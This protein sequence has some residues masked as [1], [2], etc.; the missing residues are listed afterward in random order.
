MA[1]NINNLPYLKNNN[2][3][4]EKEREISRFLLRKFQPKLRTILPQHYLF[5]PRTEESLIY[6]KEK[7]KKYPYFLRFDIDHCFPSIDQEILLQK[8][9]VA[10]K[11]L[12]HQKLSRRMAKIIEKE[13]P[14]FLET[15]PFGLPIGS[16]LSS[17]LAALYLLE[18]DLELS[19]PFLRQVDDY[20]IFCR[21]KKEPEE[22]LR[23]IVL[24]KLKELKLSLNQKKLKSGK[25]YQDKVDFLGFQFYA[26]YFQIKEEKKENF[27]RK[28]KRLTALTNHQSSDEII[29]KLN[30]QILG[31]G[32]YYKLAS[33]KGDFGDLDS[34]I[35]SRLRRYLLHQKALSSQ[36]S[37]LLLT[38]NNLEEM[39]LK[40]LLR[41]KEEFN[42][43]SKG[44]KFSLKKEGKKAKKGEKP[45]PNRKR[46]EKQSWL[47]TSQEAIYCR[48]KLV[49]NQLRE[50]TNSLKKLEKRLA[51][52]EKKLTKAK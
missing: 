41:I 13:G 9:P 22:I 51:R 23:K 15:T 34:F 21:K 5:S 25:F 36:E 49:L 43:S 33:G 30:D 38:N 4:Q 18:L 7:A 37:N 3:S 44:K 46:E 27:E 50:T 24:P 16:Y 1:K 29:K 47:A 28:I 35:R 19:R 32:H 31:F 6:L 2:I 14:A 8:I 12:T 26:G 42:S 10:Y 48:E 11:K 39:G 17:V 45:A 40:S 20:L 52:I